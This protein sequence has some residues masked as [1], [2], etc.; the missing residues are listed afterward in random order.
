MF[1]TMVTTDHNPMTGREVITAWFIQTWAPDPLSAASRL[2][3]RAKEAGA[4]AVVGVRLT[5]GGTA[6]GKEDFESWHAYGT[7]E[8]Y[9]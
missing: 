4:D 5:W 8:K 2:E 1:Q 3:H 7:A 9:G 6:V